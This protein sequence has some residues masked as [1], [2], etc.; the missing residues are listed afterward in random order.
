MDLNI[1]NYTYN[2]LLSVFKISNKNNLENVEKM[3][4]MLDV[5][6]ESYPEEIVYFFTKAYNVISCIFNLHKMNRIDSID[7]FDII[8]EYYHKIKSIKHLEN[9]NIEQILYLI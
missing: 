4:I 5:V 1:D 3:N 6:K 9:K 2:D 8:N 7:N